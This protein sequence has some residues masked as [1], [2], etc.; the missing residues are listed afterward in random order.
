VLLGFKM[1][2]SLIN[3]KSS[4]RQKK[5][6]KP[7]AQEGELG[8]VTDGRRRFTIRQ[9]WDALPLSLALQVGDGGCGW[10]DVCGWGWGWGSST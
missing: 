2:V 1:A 10:L 5:A 3:R 4:N 6:H 9:L 8:D 7:Q